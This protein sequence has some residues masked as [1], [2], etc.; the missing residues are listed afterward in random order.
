MNE[1]T[2][3]PFPLEIERLILETKA[4][5]DIP[6]AR[7]V[8]V[9]LNKRTRIWLEPIIY[10]HVVLYNFHNP[11]TVSKF[12]E[13]I[14]T[15]S[16]S[17][18]STTVQTL[19]MPFAGLSVIDLIKILTTCKSIRHLCLP[20]FGGMT[21]IGGR[22][23]VRAAVTELPLDILQARLGLIPSRFSLLG[24]PSKNIL[25]K[26]RIVIIA[27][28]AVHWMS[29]GW[30]RILHGILND[31][32]S[33]SRSV[34]P[35]KRLRFM[36]LCADSKPIQFDQGSPFVFEHP[37]EGVPNVESVLSE[38]FEN[39]THDNV[40]DASESNQSNTRKIRVRICCAHP[41]VQSDLYDGYPGKLTHW[42]HH[43]GERTWWMK[44]LGLNMHGSRVYGGDV[45]DND[46]YR[47]DRQLAGVLYGY[48]RQRA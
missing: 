14:S 40:E 3:P 41:G 34:E 37:S 43:Y 29:W 22:E 27:D 47:E 10:R 42:G 19:L 24:V 12:I 16:S 30:E 23:A 38:V 36:G 6:F 35:M 13:A 2:D 9:L 46:A 11:Q 4:K 39:R 31:E 28:Q 25:S 1:S 21:G 15:K 18:Q 5:H 8:L 7:K 20:M 26:T 45:K 32:G 44:K 48:V 17:F 33:D